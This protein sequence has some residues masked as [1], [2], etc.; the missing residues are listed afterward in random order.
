MLSSREGQS[1][2]LDKIVEVFAQDEAMVKTASDKNATLDA[3]NH[4]AAKTDPDE[5]IKELAAKSAGADSNH[6]AAK[7]AATKEI[8][9]EATMEKITLHQV[10][11]ARREGRFIKIAGRQDLYQDI[12]TK[13]FWKISDD[14]HYA[15]RTFT[16]DNNVAAEK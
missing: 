15:V 11:I 10:R 3:S 5:H 12:N 6:P 9:K 16:E 13:D 8:T 2:F 14:K 1:D 7:S 4:P